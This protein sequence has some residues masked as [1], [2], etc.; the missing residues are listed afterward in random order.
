MVFQVNAYDP[1]NFDADADPDPGSALE[2]MDPDL[3]H[4]HFYKIS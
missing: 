1:F 4:K 3:G 2:N